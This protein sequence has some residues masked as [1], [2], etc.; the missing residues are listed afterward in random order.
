MVRSRA[1]CRRTRVI[2][3][4]KGERATDSRPNRELVKRM[5]MKDEEG[6][7]GEGGAFNKNGT[8][9]M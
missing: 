5:G 2:H 4:S 6:R 9:R 1:D 3:P 7:N 8:V